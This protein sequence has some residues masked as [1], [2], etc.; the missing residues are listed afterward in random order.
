[1]PNNDY[2]NEPNQSRSED[3]IQSILDNTEYD[4]AARS[5]IEYLLIELKNAI[6][7]GGG[8]GGVTSYSPLTE[9]PKIDNH[10]L[11]A[12]NNSSSDLG[13]QTKIDADHKLSA[14]VIDDTNS[15]NKFN[16]KSDWNAASGATSEILNKPTLGTASAKNVPASGDAVTGEVVLGSDTRLTDARNAKDVYNWAKQENKPSYSYS[17]IQNTP[18]IPDELADLADDST[19]RTVTDAEKN[20][21]NGKQNALTF[22]NAP[23]SNS[24]NPVKSGGVYTA[25][26]AK[27]NNLS[28]AQM[29]AANSGATADKINKIAVNENNI[30]YIERMNGK[31]NF[32]NVN[33]TSQTI[34]TLTFTVNADKSVI[35]NGSKPSS[36]V[37]LT[38]NDSV[39]LP[40]GDYVVLDGTGASSSTLNITLFKGSSTWVGTTATGG[41]LEFTANGSDLYYCRIYI[42][43]ACDN[44]KFKPMII[45]K[46]AYD[47]GLTDYQPYALSNVELTAKEQ[48]NENNILLLEEMNGAKNYVPLDFVSTSANYTIS[49]TNRKL[50][51]NGSNT[52]ASSIYSTAYLPIGEYWLSGCPSNGSMETYVCE[53]RDNSGTGLNITDSGSGVAFTIATAGYYRYNVRL[54]AN[55]TASNLTISPMIITK[56]AKDAGFTDYQ[57][58]AMSNAELTAAKL[59]KSESYGLATAIGSSVSNPFD[60]DTLKKEGRYR[61]GSL[62]DSRSLLHAPSTAIAGTWSTSAGICT[63]EVKAMNTDNRYIQELTEVSFATTDYEIAIYRRFWNGTVW[64]KWYK[65]SGTVVT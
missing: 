31:K 44:V 34:S 37:S 29:V 63:I 30:S 47:G 13:L 7:G 38:I 5:R 46:V 26:S 60:L 54:G 55:Y 25:L 57:P 53:L 24:D 9:K 42:N 17:E 10:T 62:N 61:F 19:H 36:S 35:V 16:V 58:Y 6:E 56:A 20:T 2:A 43:Q 32:C 11:Q 15:T 49:Y 50:I 48:V 51:I 65:F 59:D 4:E 14:D 23:T 52:S 45:S 40:A 18:T 1:M 21:W 33:A 27:Q 41:K 12:G 64:G 22:D 39:Q 3:I 8:G 28:E